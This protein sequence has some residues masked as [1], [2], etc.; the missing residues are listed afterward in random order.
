MNMDISNNKRSGQVPVLGPE[1]SVLQTL[2]LSNN[3]LS[4]SIP[5][6]IYLRSPG[7]ILTSSVVVRGVE[8]VKLWRRSVGEEREE[9]GVGRER[10]K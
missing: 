2:N 9:E 1:S 3:N 8:G 7:G 6:Q 5:P 10:K 4:C